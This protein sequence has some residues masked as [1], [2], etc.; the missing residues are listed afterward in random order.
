MARVRRGVA[1]DGLLIVDKPTGIT[2]NRCLQQVK[3]LLGAAKAGHTGALDPLASG[4]LPLC[5]GEATKVSQFLLDADKIY[6]ARVRLGISTSTGDSEG[7]ITGTQAVQAFSRTAIEQVLSGFVGRIT[8]SPSI[9]SALKQNGVPLYKLARAG[10]EIVPKFREVTVY[11]INLLSWSSPDLEIEVHCSKGT[12]IRTLAEDIGKAL[13][14]GA[15]VCML[16]R[17]QAGPFSLNDSM[18]L[19]QLQQLAESGDILN[20]LVAPD[21]AIAHMPAVDLHDEQARLLRQ[22]QAVHVAQMP[23]QMPQQMP[24][25]QSALVRVYCGQA[26][27]GIGELDD[28]GLLISRRLLSTADLA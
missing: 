20:R 7:E 27:L 1:I 25:S 6:R 11:R 21:R 22:G 12:Y 10:K 18:S 15:H 17:S 3:H 8:Q 26:F 9:Y 13:G 28:K 19:Q 2:S 16:R 4:V 23:Q 14:C 24:A 5:F